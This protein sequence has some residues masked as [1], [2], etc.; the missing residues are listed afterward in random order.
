MFIYPKDRLTGKK[1]GE[2]RKRVFPFMIHSHLWF[3][4]RTVSVSRCGKGW[5][6]QARSKDWFLVSH[7]LCHNASSSASYLITYPT[8]C[9][10]ILFLLKI[11]S[12]QSEKH[13]HRHIVRVFKVKAEVW[14]GCL[15]IFCVVCNQAP[16]LPAKSVED[17][18]LSYVMDYELCFLKA[19]A[20]F[21]LTKIKWNDKQKYNERTS[22]T[23]EGKLPITI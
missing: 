5:S 9:Y 1:G 20:I 19:I 2:E 4:S 15:S 12:G 18:C 11:I 10:P 6:Q 3:I 22:K 21:H 17:V 14:S 13:K 23:S 8:D 7:Q 16:F